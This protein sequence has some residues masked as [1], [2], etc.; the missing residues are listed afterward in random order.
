MLARSRGLR[1]RDEREY[2]R[3]ESIHL[4]TLRAALQEQQIDPDPLEVAHAIRDLVGGADK[5][6]A[7]PA[8]RDAVVLE[9]DLRLE[10]RAL[11][12]VLVARVPPRARV[13]SI[14]PASASGGSPCI[15]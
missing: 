5:A 15:R 7:Q 1:P 12:E 2:L 13:T 3:G 6:G 10:L 8:I 9:R 11:D 4:F 14:F